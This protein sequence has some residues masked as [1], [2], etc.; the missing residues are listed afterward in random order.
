MA[1]GISRAECIAFILRYNGGTPL[2]GAVNV[3]ANL[4]P[5]DRGLDRPQDQPAHPRCWV[6]RRFEL[7]P[8]GTEPTASS[9]I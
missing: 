5:I 6:L 8:G 7:T 1:D 9:G 4:R 2:C 3:H